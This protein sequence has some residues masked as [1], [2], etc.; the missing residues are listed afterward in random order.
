MTMIRYDRVTRV[1]I[2]LRKHVDGVDT[3]PG[4]WIAKLTTEYHNKPD[5]CNFHGP[6]W[7]EG[8]TLEEA[9]GKVVEHFKRGVLEEQEYDDRRYID[10]VGTWLDKCAAGGVEEDGAPG[11]LLKL[12]LGLNYRGVSDDRIKPEDRLR[13]A[14]ILRDYC[15]KKLEGG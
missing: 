7:S 14:M 12:L 4:R 13:A 3:P 2:E 5:G 8:E 10:Y 1:S 6:R 15:A 9:L 11:Y